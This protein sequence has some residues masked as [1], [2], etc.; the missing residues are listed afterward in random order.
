MKK[1]FYILILLSLFTNSY[2]QFYD[3][4]VT[5]ESDSIA[6]RIDSITDTHIYFEMKV[7]NN[8]FHTYTN[9]N[10]IVEYKRDAIDKRLFVFKAGTSYIESYK[11]QISTT[12]KPGIAAFIELGGKGYYSA[13]ID[14]RLKGNHRLSI[15][16]TELD[17]DYFD[18]EI[19]HGTETSHL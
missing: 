1:L 16:I 9:K 3:L 2:G 12:N 14:F 13:N 5:H 18:E 19:G 11:L 10:D 8:W 17:Y 7:N 15:G 4:I 6:C